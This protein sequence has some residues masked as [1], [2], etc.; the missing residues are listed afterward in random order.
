[1]VFSIALA[2]S[3]GGGRRGAGEVGGDGGAA[4]GGAPATSG[5]SGG[6]APGNPLFRSERVPSTLP[7]RTGAGLRR[8][9]PAAPSGRA[10]SPGGG[11]S[12]R[13]AGPEDHPPS[14]GEGVRGNR[15][16]DRADDSGHGPEI[17]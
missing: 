10:V 7:G 14:V 13:A 12:R 11:I 4:V 8:R 2:V 17:R 6:S 5:R 16:V 1:M 9:C 3:G 15:P